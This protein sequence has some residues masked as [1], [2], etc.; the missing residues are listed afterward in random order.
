[1]TSNLIKGLKPFVGEIL[2][3][4]VEPE[5]LIDKYAVALLTDYKIVG[6]LRKEKS[7]RFT[8]TIFYFLKASQMS[9]AVVTVEGKK[10]N[11]GDSDCKSFVI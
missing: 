11:V 10:V 7:G 2:R 3:T 4:R 5:N 6:H 9:S 8:K 1:M